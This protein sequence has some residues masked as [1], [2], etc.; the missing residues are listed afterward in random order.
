MPS[1]LYVVG[2]GPGAFQEMTPRALKALEDSDIIYGYRTY[3]ELI[4]GLFNEDKQIISSGMMSEEARCAAAL[5]KAAEGNIVSIVSS[6]D[7]NVYGMASLIVELNG[8]KDEIEIEVVSG[9]TAATSG[10]ALL[11]A[12][13]SSDFAV[14]SLSDLLTPWEL[15]EKR[16]RAAASA[17]FA[18]VLYNPASTKRDTHLARAC[19]IVGEFYSPSTP[20]AIVRNIAREGEEALLFTLAELS[21][22]KAD[23][24]STVFIGNSTTVTLGSHML[25]PR[26]YHL[27]RQ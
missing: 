8:G 26:G 21:E 20:C 2:I 6:G 3:T 24:F 4:K 22:A 11:G 16:L 17:D 18:I 19:S 9:I 27:K 23:M 13:L 25:T 5:A 1:K 7:P 14:I 15:I 12:P 10:A